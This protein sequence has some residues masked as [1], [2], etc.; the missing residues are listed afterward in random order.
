MVIAVVM[1]NQKL[2]MRGIAATAQ[3]LGKAVI[4]GGGSTTGITFPEQR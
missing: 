4:I 2:S 3:I 1:G